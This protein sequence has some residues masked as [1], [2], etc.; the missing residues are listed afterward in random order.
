MIH[1]LG[2]ANYLSKFVPNLSDTT[3]PL[4]KLLRKPVLFYWYPEQQAAFEKLKHI[5]TSSPV[6][7]IFDIDKSIELHVDS[8]QGGIGCV[9]AKNRPIAYAY[10]A[11]TLTDSMSICAD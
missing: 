1:L 8:S 5:L 9:D 6:L 7:A 2:M 10:C 3:A 11:V 4:R